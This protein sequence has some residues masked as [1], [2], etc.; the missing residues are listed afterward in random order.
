MTKTKKKRVLKILSCLLGTAALL[1]AAWMGTGYSPLTDAGKLHRMERR[2]LLAPSELALEKTAQD[3]YGTQ[4]M[5]VG[6]NG[7][8]Y[9]VMQLCYTPQINL[10]NWWGG[11]SDGFAQKKTELNILESKCQKM[12]CVCAQ[13]NC[14]AI[15]A[16]LYIPGDGESSTPLVLSWQ[17]PG[18]DKGVYGFAVPEQTDADAER[19]TEAYRGN[20]LEHCYY[21]AALYDAAGSV[22]A[23]YAADLG[24]ASQFAGILK[25]PET[26]MAGFIAPD[27]SQVRFT[28]DGEHGVAIS[29]GDTLTVPFDLSDPSVYVQ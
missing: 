4:K 15:G 9:T 8:Q 11:Y 26:M 19:L 22:T 14:A 1:F 10:L 6:D 29:F 3:E 28:P 17:S 12:F 27:L 2:M 20:R 21:L 13:R 24:T 5:A 23:L 25:F 7:T 16:V 18:T